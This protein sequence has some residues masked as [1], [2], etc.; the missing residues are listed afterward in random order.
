M[1]CSKSSENAMERNKQLGCI[2]TEI[3]YSHTKLN[4][5]GAIL[6]QRNVQVRKYFEKQVIKNMLKENKTCL[7]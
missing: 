7:K 2:E 1:D 5:I 4:N 6:F 3:S